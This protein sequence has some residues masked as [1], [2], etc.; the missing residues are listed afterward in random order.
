MH[1]LGN[2]HLI[3][4]ERFGC[5]YEPGGCVVWSHVLLVGSQR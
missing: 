3:V 5:L 2:H 4:V 1:L